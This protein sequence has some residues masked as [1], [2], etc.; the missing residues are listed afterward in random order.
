[1]FFN[2][3]DFCCCIRFEP[4]PSFDP[5]PSQQLHCEISPHRVSAAFQQLKRGS[6]KALI[7]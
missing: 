7:R 6:G 1:M 3:F 2:N 5:A 4:S